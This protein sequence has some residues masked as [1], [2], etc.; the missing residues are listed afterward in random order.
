MAS[1]N[2]LA[3]RERVVWGRWEARWLPR[4]CISN[5]VPFLD[6]SASRVRRGDGLPQRPVQFDTKWDAVSG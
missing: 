3:L 1:A 5:S 2:N 6:E 4:L